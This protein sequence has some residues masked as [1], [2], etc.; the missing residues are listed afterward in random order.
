MNKFTLFLI[1]F[2]ISFADAASYDRSEW[3]SS[4]QWKKARINALAR[5]QYENVWICGYTDTIIPETRALDIDHIIPIKYAFDNGGAI[6]STT[7][8][9]RFATDSENLVAVSQHANRS[10]GDKGLS[11][12][13]PQ[14]HVCFY[15]SHW[16]LISKKYS[17]KLQKNDQQVL[18]SLSNVC[19]LK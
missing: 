19:Y 9:R 18:D 12:Y 13:L 5:A 11:R 1:A 3:I 7:K 6:W 17:L 16:K 10:K 2:L 8:K 4:S 14:K 15:A